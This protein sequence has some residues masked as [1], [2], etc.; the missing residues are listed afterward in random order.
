MPFARTGAG[1]SETVELRFDDGSVR[2]IL[3]RF[4]TRL[5]AGSD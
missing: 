2:R 3:A 5:T 1:D 4:V